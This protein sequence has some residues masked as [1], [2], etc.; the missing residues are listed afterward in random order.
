MKFAQGDFYA[1][2]WK[3]GYR[4]IGKHTYDQGDMYIGEFLEDE[5]EGY[6]YYAGVNRVKYIGNWKMNK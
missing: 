6:G 4:I 1:G 2:M 5:F 3:D